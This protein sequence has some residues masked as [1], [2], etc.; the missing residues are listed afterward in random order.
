MA[1]QGLREVAAGCTP[2]GSDGRVAVARGG[3]PLEAVWCRFPGA[4]ASFVPEAMPEGLPRSGME[5]SG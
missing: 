1:Y 5:F 2:H 4:K 3:G